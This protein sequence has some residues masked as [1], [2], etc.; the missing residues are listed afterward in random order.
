M[1]TH[2]RTPRSIQK[3]TRAT[4]LGC[5]FVALAFSQGCTFGGGGE[6]AAPPPT[7]G[8]D[9][10]EIAQPPPPPPLSEATPPPPPPAAL[11]TTGFPGV[12]HEYPDV[13]GEGPADRQDRIV[14]VFYGTDRKW[15]PDYSSPE[16]YYGGER[17]DLELGICRVNIPPDHQLGELEEPK[18]YRLEF[19][20]NP[21]RHV[22]V[23]DIRRRLPEEVWLRAVNARIGQSEDQSAFVFIHGYNTSFHDAARRAGQMAYDLRFQGA[24]ILYS[25][26][27]QAALAGYTVDENNVRNS[28]RHLKT[29]LDLLVQRS[30][31]RVVHLI[32]HSMGNRALTAALERLASEMP[33]ESAPLF[34]Q[35]ALVAP[36]VDAEVFKQDIMPAIQGVSSRISLYASAH[37]KALEA[38]SQVHGGYPRAGNLEDGVVI[39]PGLDTIDASDVETGFLAHSYFAETPSVISDLILLFNRGLGPEERSGLSAVEHPDG[40][41]WKLVAQPPTP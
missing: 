12:A 5:L 22:M 33:P 25:W 31:A 39:A 35:I 7:V 4:R 23:L 27:S 17:G 14:E 21:E 16:D 41:Y 6:T 24:P 20:W 18:W 32:A 26:P 10:G 2:L 34:N 11:Q 15:N 19:R 3:W 37:D 13:D 29:F 1:K 30:D 36:D 40:T 28:V 38:S 8:G 9:G